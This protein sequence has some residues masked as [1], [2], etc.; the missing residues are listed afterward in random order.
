MKKFIDSYFSIS[1][2]GSCLKKEVLGGVTTFMAMAYILAVQPA[3]MS[4]AG[5]PA[6]PVLV[7]VAVASGLATLFMGLYAKYPFALAPGMGTNI[8]FAY[9]LVAGGVFTWQQSL[10]IVFIAGALFVLLTAFGFREAIAKALPGSI[11]LGIGASVGVF[12]V[13][14][15]MKNA[16]IMV[17][18]KTGMARG[19]FLSPETLLAVIGLLITIFLQIKGVLGALLIGILSVTIIGIPMGVTKM[20]SSLFALPPSIVPISLQLDFSNLFRPETLPFIFVFF[21]GDFFS[22]LGT[23]LGVSS[24]A[25]FLDKD[26]NLPQIEKPFLVDALATVGGSLMGVTTLTTYVESASGVAAG[27][28]SGFTSVVT[29]LVFF[30]SIFFTPLFLMIPS[31]ATAPCLIIIGFMLLDGLRSINFG[32]LDDTIAPLSM[33]TVTAYTSSMSNGIAV[34]VLLYTFIKIIKGEFKK[35]HPVMVVMCA[36]FIYYLIA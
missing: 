7:A 14:L 18:T 35:I 13:Y 32:V 34:G 4:V 10:S 16:G 19:N 25:G 12:L 17:F 26:G 30:I 20:P 2:R 11:K 1:Q 3:L 29:S 9:T 36:V 5:M 28:R 15:G 24:K 22:T 31:A 6:G 27:G 8:F 23:L 21:I 33:L